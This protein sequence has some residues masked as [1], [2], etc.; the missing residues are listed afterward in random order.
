MFELEAVWEWILDKAGHGAAPFIL[1]F[2]GF[3][4]YAVVRFIWRQLRRLWCFFSSRSRTLSA[5]RR[6]YSKDGPREGKGLWLTKPI[7]P[8]ENYEANLGKPLVLV[9]GNSQPQ[10]EAR[11]NI[12]R[13]AEYI[14]RQIGLPPPQA[15]EVTARNGNGGKKT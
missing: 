12:A 10:Q 14:G 5:V 11:Q 6:D 2:L 15:H 7:C 9:V 4:G 8:P 1:G 3:I 13:L